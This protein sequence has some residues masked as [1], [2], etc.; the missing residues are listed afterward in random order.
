MEGKQTYPLRLEGEMWRGLYKIKEI[1]GIPV[2][3][4][5]AEAIKQYLEKSPHLKVKE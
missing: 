5:I 3:W 2:C 1:T 4:Q